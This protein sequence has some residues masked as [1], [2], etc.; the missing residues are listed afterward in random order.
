MLFKLK[1]FLLL[2]FKGPF[3][4][5]Q[6]T[7]SVMSDFLRLHE[8]KHVRPPCPSPT[9]RVHSNPCP[10][11]RWCHPT[12]WPSTVPFSSCPQYLPTSGSIEMSQLFASG[13]QNI[14]VSVSTSVLPMNTQDWHPLG[15]TGRPS[16]SS[17]DSQGS[18]PT[19]QF[20]TWILWLSAFF[21]VQ[22]SHPYMTTRKT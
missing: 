21:R 19:P 5:V 18:S 10:L 2:P 9:P 1:A 14:G 13:G 7:H 3:S 12:I 16:C 20:K 8:P 4:S 22:L 15:W 11:S 6:F 17:R